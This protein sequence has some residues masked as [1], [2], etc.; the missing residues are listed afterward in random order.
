[1]D[2]RGYALPGMKLLLIGETSAIA[3]ALRPI[4]E[5]RYDVTGQSSRRFPE[6][7][8]YDVV[9]NCAGLSLIN[10]L[11]MPH[12]LNNK[13]IEVNCNL[14]VTLLSDFLYPMQQRKFGRIIFLSSVC[15]EINLKGH[16]VYSAS[17]AFIDKLVKIAALENAE[18]GITVNSI[19][20]G[21]TGIG[22][23]DIPEEMERMRNKPAL[24]RFCTMQELSNAI[25]FIVDTEYY[26]GQ[27]LRLDGF[28]K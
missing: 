27:N 2:I 28:I 26:T 18:Y 21:Y 4:F 7:L 8:D 10:D 3:Q 9:I 19:Q 23:S 11:A 5:Q 17:K 20:L 22:M 12:L 14:A 15:S 6:S 16:G 13:V 24:K 1:M 25:N